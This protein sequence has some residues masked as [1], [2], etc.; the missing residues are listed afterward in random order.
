MDW[1]IEGIIFL[2]LCVFFSQQHVRKTELFNGSW[3]I[4]VLFVQLSGYVKWEL[5]KDDKGKT[6][7]NLVCWGSSRKQEST[8][9]VDLS[10]VV[11]QSSDYLLVKAFLPISGDNLAVS[12]GVLGSCC[13]NPS[14]VRHLCKWKF[15]RSLTTVRPLR[16]NSETLLHRNQSH[17]IYACDTTLIAGKN[18][19]FVIHSYFCSSDSSFQSELASPFTV[20]TKEWFIL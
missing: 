13:P 18:F 7:V 19:M 3:R 16:G 8:C 15:V 9:L 6:Q 1:T 2:Q 11:R 17:P 20:G 14:E 5:V 10:V 12:M 4:T